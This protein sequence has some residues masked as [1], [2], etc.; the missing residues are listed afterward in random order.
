M[1]TNVIQFSQFKKP[2]PFPEPLSPELIELERLRYIDS[3]IDDLVP[4]IVS[5]LIECGF[6]VTGDKHVK[7]VALMVESV[8]AAMFSAD[9]RHH[10]LH[11]I[12]NK[13]NVAPVQ[14]QR[15]FAANTA[16]DC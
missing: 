14:V 1:T 10:G 7:D 4:D 8:R 6:D 3:I 5:S 15:T 12:S 13:I 16:I 11:I 9:G 2:T